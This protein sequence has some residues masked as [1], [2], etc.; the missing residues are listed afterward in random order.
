MKSALEEAMAEQRVVRIHYISQDGHKTT[1]DVE[2][3]IFAST[4]GRWYLV[5]WCRLRNAMRWFLITRIEHATVTKTLCGDHSVKE[6]GTPPTT[7]RSLHADDQPESPLG[8]GR[9][10]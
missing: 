7:A 1:R 9:G 5:G 4:N 2:P 8:Y 3:V 6:I 10:S